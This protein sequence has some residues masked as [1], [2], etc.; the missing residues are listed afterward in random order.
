MAV[1]VR[2]VK[3]RA[4]QVPWPAC[5]Y[6][7]YSAAARH[8]HSVASL[9]EAKPALDA[10][11]RVVHFLGVGPRASRVR[12]PGVAPNLQVCV[13]HEADVEALA[14]HN[15][16]DFGR[17]CREVGLPEDVIMR[18]EMHAAY[19]RACAEAED[20]VIHATTDEKVREA[21]GIV[22]CTS[23]RA[24]LTLLK[25]TQAT[26]FFVKKLQ[27]AA[28]SLGKRKNA[29]DESMQEKRAAPKPKVDKQK[30]S[31]PQKQVALAPT[32]QPASDDISALMKIEGLSAKCWDMMAASGWETLKQAS[33]EELYRMPGVSFFDFRPNV[34]IFDTLEKACKQF[35]KLWIKDTID[36]NA[37]NQE[38]LVEFAWP[39]ALAS[40]WQTMTNG[41]ETWFI[42][43]NTPFDKW[44]PN[45]TM[46]PSKEQ[47]VAKFLAAS[48]LGDISAESADDEDVRSDAT[49]PL[50]QSESEEVDDEEMSS[51]QGEPKSDDSSIGDSDS[52]EDCTEDEEAVSVAKATKPKPSRVRTSSN[53]KAKRAVSLSLSP[54]KPP[55]PKKTAPAPKPV[56]QKKIPP[57]TLRL[58]MIEVEIRKLGWFWKSN[59][60]GYAYYRPHCEGKADSDLT[61]N[62]DYFLDQ[63]SLEMYLSTTGQKDEI[64]DTC[65]YAHEC[66]YGLHDDSSEGEDDE[67]IAEIAEKELTKQIQSSEAPKAQPKETVGAATKAPKKPRKKPAS[68]PVKRNA[69]NTS[70]RK[71]QR[72]S[73]SVPEVKFGFVWKILS[74]EGW[75]YKPGKFEYDYFMPHCSDISEG[76]SMV[77]YFPTKD[78]LIDYLKTSGIWERVARQIAAEDEASDEEQSESEEIL[79]L[80]PQERGQKRKNAE[81][82]KEQKLSTAKKS[83]QSTELQTPV[84]K[85]RV[86]A[87]ITPTFF[88][89]QDDTI[90]PDAAG[91]KET[92]HAAVGLSAKPRNLANIF[93]PSPSNVKKPKLKE[94][95]VSSLAKNDEDPVSRAIK[96]LTASYTPQKLR[97]RE[98]EF[99]EIRGFFR[100]CFMQRRGASLYIS[101]APGCGKT[102]LLK[103]TEGE[104]D[105]LHKVCVMNLIRTN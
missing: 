4:M 96:R 30:K 37:S 104:I 44:A 76:K 15:R 2:W 49:E 10:E 51:S 28:S 79:S 72:T 5:V 90:S 63:D 70:S 53:P 57:F 40:G 1:A 14:F 29:L 69:A 59:S 102:A 22:I 24:K 48:G 52:G 62:E 17:I 84:A 71:R 88:M 8:M 67:P 75:H 54:E 74:E 97:Y 33:G 18:T 80:T 77:D 73:S 13:A 58:G 81:G 20:L 100:Q 55:Q 11:D 68:G 99:A 92:E 82:K 34:T 101:G 19:Q 103:S 95:A 41:N 36:G 105:A 23:E 86:L 45:V 85:P 93:T 27:D 89:E 16:H 12:A 50:N 39:L 43:P 35:L 26:E 87:D 94:S 25:C 42:M 56:V 91:T 6:E 3:L 9:R 31:P 7:D 47:A 98:S 61:V 65:L 64:Y 66:K 78:L 38:D 21:L 46:F 83:K 60:M 32:T